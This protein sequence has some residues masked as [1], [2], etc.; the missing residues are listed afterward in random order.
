[1][2]VHLVAYAVAVAADSVHLHNQVVFP[3]SQGRVLAVPSFDQAVGLDAL[4]EQRTVKP[5]DVNAQAGAP[6]P[7]EHDSEFLGLR[8]FRASR[9]P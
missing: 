3:H 8:H 2:P 5:L 7:V 6:P 1:V 4:D 9:R